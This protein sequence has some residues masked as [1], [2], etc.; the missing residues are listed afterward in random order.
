MSGISELRPIGLVGSFDSY[1]NP[2]QARATV[3]YELDRLTPVELSVTDAS[4]RRV[5]T[6]VDASQSA[7]RYSVDWDASGVAPGVYF[8]S[9]RSGGRTL[10]R[11]L[12]VNR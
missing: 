1:P 5:S 6:L 12:V 8:C 7:G 3:C 2:V 11:Q 9:L 10:T 4:G